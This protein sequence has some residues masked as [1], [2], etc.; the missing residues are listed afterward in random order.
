MTAW[1]IWRG[2]IMDDARTMECRVVRTEYEKDQHPTHDVERLYNDAMGG[3]ELAADRSGARRVDRA[4]I[5]GAR[6]RR[7]T[8]ARA[9]VSP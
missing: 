6:A 8:G 3:G 4:A 1:V 5:H 2:V 9:G 7:G